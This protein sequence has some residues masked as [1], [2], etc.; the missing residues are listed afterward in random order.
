MTAVASQDP[1]YYVSGVG[2]AIQLLPVEDYIT[3]EIYDP[4]AS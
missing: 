4:Q 2:S 3:P 1:Q